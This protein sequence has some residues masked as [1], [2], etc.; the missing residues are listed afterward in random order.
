MEDNELTHSPQV[1]QALEK[2]RLA[3]DLDAGISAELAQ[4]DLV[5]SGLTADKS[6]LEGAI[7][8]QEDAL[9]L[10][11]ELPDSPFPEEDAVRALDRQIRVAKSRVKL[12]SERRAE[13]RA[14]I[15]RL[16]V[17]LRAEFCAFVTEQLA[18]VRARYRAAALLLRNLYAE[19]VPWIECAGRL[20][21][22]VPTLEASIIIDPE[23]KKAIFDARDI[24]RV[25]DT[26]K[27]ICGSLHKQ[28]GG[29]LAEVTAATE[30]DAERKI[31]RAGAT[32]PA[33]S[34]CSSQGAEALAL[35]MEA[36]K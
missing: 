12:V 19:Q 5:L 4:A 35:A 36:R 17:A 32:P 3:R 33:S 26:W 16:K 21:L 13:S 22:S 34:S 15:G 27:A 28:L 23:K 6:G 31:S 14:H 20:G 29:L 25:P 8:Q 7:K 1:S 18:D 10:S 2:L 11:G 9:A 30:E 24:V